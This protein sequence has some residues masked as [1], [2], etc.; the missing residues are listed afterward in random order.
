MSSLL[1]LIVLFGG[2]LLQLCLY[3]IVWV[4]EDP[5]ILAMSLSVSVLCV[6]HSPN[7]SV[8]ARLPL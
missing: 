1:L 7:A 6:E 8:N 5:L 2:D 3:E 4:F